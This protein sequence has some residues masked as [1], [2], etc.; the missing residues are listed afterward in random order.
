MGCALNQ[1]SKF[2]A[3]LQAFRQRV[4]S[5]STGSPALRKSVYGSSVIPFAGLGSSTPSEIADRNQ[6]IGNRWQS[7]EARPVHRS[8]NV[9]SG[10]G[11]TCLR[12]WAF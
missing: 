2:S 11:T 9:P 6:P 4:K 10:W 8:T 3:H 12:S 5:G 1:H 7:C